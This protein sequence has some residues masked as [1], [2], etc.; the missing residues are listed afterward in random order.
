[1]QSSAG[2]HDI[3]NVAD[4]LVRQLRRHQV[5]F[6]SGYNLPRLFEVQQRRAPV[7]H[8][9]V[10]TSKNSMIN[11]KPTL[12]GFNR[13]WTCPD[14]C[15]LPRLLGTHDESVSPPVDEILALRKENVPERSVTPIAGAAQEH[16]TSTNPTREKDAVAIVGQQRVLNHGEGLEVVG[17]SE[18]DR[19][20]MIAIAPRDVV[21]IFD[22]HDARVVTVLG[23][24]D[25]MIGNIPFNR[26]WVDVPIEPILTDSSVESHLALTIVASEYPREPI[27]ELNRSRVEDGV[28]GG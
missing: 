27:S 20:S 10:A 11:Q 4:L 3:L 15:A 12:T 28:R 13:D 19:R 2:E 5:G 14:L 9:S 16:V 23:F 1:V 6:G 22:P 18:T 17:I 8:I 26:S 25:V 7:V 21:A 24:A